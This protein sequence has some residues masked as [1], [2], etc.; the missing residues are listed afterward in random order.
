VS[1]PSDATHGRR[2]LA[3]ALPAAVLARL[4]VLLLLAAA[5]ADPPLPPGAPAWMQGAV[6]VLL[7]RDRSAAVQRRAGERFDASLARALR[8]LPTGS[9]VALV[10]YGQAA[11]R[12][13]PLAVAADFRWPADGD[14]GSVGGPRGGLAD[15][16]D[17]ALA[18][19]EAARP[20]RL[21]LLGDGEDAGA[22][23][24]PQPAVRAALARA[25][26]AAVAAHWFDVRAG[27]APA[28]VWIDALHVPAQ[29][30]SGSRLPV[31]V[32]VGSQGL[33]SATLR[34]WV[35]QSLL[36]EA[37][38]R[39][40]LRTDHL[41]WLPSLA[42]GHHEVVVQVWAGADDV[43]GADRRAA[44][45]HV[46]GPASV[47]YVSRAPQPPLARS[48]AASGW[49][50]DLS[51]PD[52]LEQGLHAQPA[53]VVLD[54]VAVHDISDAALGAL[55]RA[56]RRDGTGLLVLG[57]PD[58]FA[59]G[60]YRG[61][62]LEALLPVIAEPPVPAAPVAVLFL[63]D[64]SG[65]MERG[66]QHASAL[67]LAR[68][69]V[70]QTANALAAG[71]LS[72]VYAFDVAPRLLLPLAAREHAALQ[73]LQALA[74]APSGGTRLAAAL[75]AALDDLGSAPVERRIL[76]VVTDARLDPGDDLAAAVQRVRAARAQV[77]LL[78]VGDAPVA[79]ALRALAQAGDGA[80]L[81]VAEVAELP[82]IMRRE[83]DARRAPPE[84]GRVLP[85]PVQPLPFL[86]AVAAWPALD[87][88]APTRPRLRASV[89]LRTP[90]GAPLLAVHDAGAGRVAALPGGL[91]GWAGDWI[92]WPRFAELADGLAR[93]L[94]ATDHSTRLHIRVREERDALRVVVDALA[95]RREWLQ[96]E[97]AMLQ[98]SAPQRSLQPALLRTA[99][100]R[101]EAV[102][103]APQPGRHVFIAR[104]GDAFARHVHL[105][106]PAGQ[107]HWSRRKVL[108]PA[109]ALG[110]VTR[111]SG[112]ASVRIGSAGAARP[113]LLALAALA[114]MLVLVVESVRGRPRARAVRAQR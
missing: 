31:S 11:P 12:L 45:V 24:D 85:V 1:A 20:T 17:A 78:V 77:L 74:T 61:S 26:A 53:L 104:V 36:H 100:G 22:G 92:A 32:Q 96:D 103:E 83:L 21:L 63:V 6:D 37:P 27:P 41:L 38:L 56:V 55:T 114:Y 76:V 50:L 67:A 60:G 2:R 62:P 65:S 66:A 109:L 94:A 68:Q 91:A 51:V 101:F 57:G 69:A 112:A 108:E 79:P 73:A 80:V 99:P 16:I 28:A 23:H 81:Q 102:V 75:H 33:A 71:D 39:L 89:Y 88:F 113:W 19:A 4:L 72:G 7:V 98:V 15:A 13:R 87:G 14:P 18:L 105:Q 42:S 3:A 58:A 48:L 59:G 90:S 52:Q 110:L 106:P 111:A 70:V 25:N 54:D 5:W 8:A 64:T 97:L 40:P 49:P 30:V 107:Q 9:R 44:L 43:A 29:L 86:D 84:R 95:P 46:P 82:R 10:E 93:W 34:V 47:L 35:E